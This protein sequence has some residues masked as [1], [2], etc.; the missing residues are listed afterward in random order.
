V[1]AETIS[2]HVPGGGVEMI[3]LPCSKTV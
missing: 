3:E 1:I 2:E